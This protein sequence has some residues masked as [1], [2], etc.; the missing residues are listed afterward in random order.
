LNLQRECGPNDVRVKIAYCGICGSDIHE[1]LDGPIFPPLPGQKNPHTGVELPVTLGHEM[2]G[3]VGEVGS[4]VTNIRPG[5]KC[6]INP[7]VDDRHHGLEP[8]KSCRAG[9]PNL[10]KHW[11][12]Y[13][14]SAPGGGLA[15]EI[16]V[17]VASVLLVPSSVSLKA[18]ALAEPL[19]VACHMARISGFQKGDS[20][21]ILGAGP[22]GLALLLFLKAKG[23]G[24]IIIS[25]IS[26]LRAQ[27]AREFGADI[28]IN[29]IKDAKDGGIVHLIHEATL[30]GVD[31]A[32]DASGLQS[33]LDT[34]IA[35]T[36]PGGTIFNVAIHGKPLMIQPN[37]ITLTEKKYMGGIC[38]T[39]QDFEEVIRALESGKL[40]AEAMI[41]SIVPL[42]NVVNGAFEELINN[43]DK[44]IKILVQP[45]GSEQS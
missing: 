23:A 37:D 17:N 39:M 31:I 33:T 2:S 26:E 3:I 6:T 1:Y 32:F 16:I 45:D 20:V 15:D 9:K 44:H 21:L 38:Y 18:A 36:R 13:G 29:P 10:C 24:K 4:N 19:A 43:K 22:I 14:L 7:S 27:K 25:E 35:A 41:T 30:D 40:P 42:D 11:A 34:A 8:C 28:V 5:Q 12:C